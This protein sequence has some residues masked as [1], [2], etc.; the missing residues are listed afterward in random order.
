MVEEQPT[1]MSA[2]ELKIE[3]LQKLLRGKASR[4]FQAI[5]GRVMSDM[6]ESMVCAAGAYVEGG[7]SNCF[8]IIRVTDAQ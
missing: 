1:T 7:Y 6:L 8:K 3:R 2:L 4:Q 5:C